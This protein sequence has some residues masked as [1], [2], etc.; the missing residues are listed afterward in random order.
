MST[1]S[2]PTAEHPFTDGRP[3]HL[4]CGPGDICEDVLL[5]GDPDRVALLAARLD[6]VRDFGRRREFAV[7]SG[8]YKGH[9]LTICSTGIGGS[10]TE[11]ALMELSLLGAKR[12]VRTGGMSSL[13]AEI[14]TGAF[15]CVEKATGY[16]S[17]AKLYS[18]DENATAYADRD[19]YLALLNTNLGDD[20][21]IVSGMVGSTDSYYYGQDRTQKPSS[22][23][24]PK[25]SYLKD[26]QE[27]GAVGVDM[28]CQTVLSVAPSLGLKA[29]CLLGVHGNRATN[30]W[31]VDYE[32]T[33]RK[34]LDI[35][36]IALA[37]SKD[38]H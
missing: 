26:L 32:P 13:V 24:A 8:T 1:S 3:P 28:E 10:S 25:I 19:L 33:Q 38:N 34:L 29:A 22:G 14:P 11:I 9:P 12:V 15:L 36:G 2:K 18:G 37:R 30:D 4:P 17:L 7:I 35:A 31:L 5:P 16:S 20:T 27:R 23:T 6:D 21:R